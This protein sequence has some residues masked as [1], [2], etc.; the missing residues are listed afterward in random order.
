FPRTPH[1][2]ESIVS[3]SISP[4][5]L[6]TM[7]ER[8]IYAA[9]AKETR[10]VLTGVHHVVK[11]NMLKCVSTDSHRLAQYV[12]ELDEE[13]EEIKT[14]IPA[15]VL[16]EAKKHLDASEYEAK[17]HFHETQVVYEF[18]DVTLY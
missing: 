5:I 13:Y 12:Y 9:S 1:V 16:N 8:T 6:S 4:D 10:P 11:G 14:T 3:L 17:I 18:D 7:Y 2:G 15:K